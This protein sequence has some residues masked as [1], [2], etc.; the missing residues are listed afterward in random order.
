MGPIEEGLNNVFEKL[1]SVREKELPIVAFSSL[2]R[3]RSNII[4]VWMESNCTIFNDNWGRLA[5]L[6]LPTWDRMKM[7]LN[8]GRPLSLIALDTMAN[9]FIRGGD[10]VVEQFSP[11]ILGK[12]KK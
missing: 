6:C 8:K 1:K 12:E 5:A 9:C 2:Y 10:P 7:W 11:K 3:F 4:L